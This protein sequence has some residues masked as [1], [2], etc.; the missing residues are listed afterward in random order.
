MVGDGRF[1]QKPLEQGFVVPFE[2]NEAGRKRITDE[3][4]QH[5]T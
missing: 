1:T 2:C 3:P 5:P 4:V